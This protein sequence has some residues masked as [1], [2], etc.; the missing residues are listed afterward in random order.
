MAHI[1]NSQHLLSVNANY[2]LLDGLQTT[3]TRVEPTLTQERNKIQSSGNPNRDKLNVS[4]VRIS[5]L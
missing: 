5:T 4:F 3:K 1:F 2:S